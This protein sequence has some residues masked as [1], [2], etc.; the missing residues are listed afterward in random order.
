MAKK[1]DWKLPVYPEE[2]VPW[3][4]LEAGKALP[5]FGSVGCYW[6]RSNGQVRIS[7]LDELVHDGSTESIYLSAEL[8][9]SLRNTEMP[10]WAA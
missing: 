1:A 3:S 5:V 7:K 2:L 10:L 6:V 4:A 9:Q 8:I